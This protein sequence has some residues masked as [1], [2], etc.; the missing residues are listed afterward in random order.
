MSEAYMHTI[1]LELLAADAKL[2]RF[3]GLNCRRLKF[4]LFDAFLTHFDALLVW[5]PCT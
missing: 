3:H 5:V 4:V 1:V 2:V